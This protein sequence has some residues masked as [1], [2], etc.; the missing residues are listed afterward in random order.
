MP[1]HEELMGN[2]EDALFALLVEKCM[3]K[4]GER[5]L[6]LNEELK[7][8]SKGVVPAGAYKRGLRTIDR[9][10]RK[11]WRQTAGR[12]TGKVLSRVAIAVC[13]LMLLFMTAFAVSPTVRQQVY[14]LVMEVMD[15]STEL[16]LVGDADAASPQ[17]ALEGG[18]VSV[19]GY[20]EPVVPEGFEL[21]N[22]WESEG[23][24]LRL[25]VDQLGNDIQLDIMLAADHLS[26]S[27]DTEHADL[28][29]H[30]QINELEGLYVIKGNVVAY[31]LADTKRG[32]HISVTGTNV[33]G[34]LIRAILEQISYND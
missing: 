2:Y 22:R 1:R 4:E 7:R 9:A 28:I 12:V 21:I 13:C 16:S 23:R 32:V 27:V 25:Y 26:H 34:D 11:Q 10:F 31:Y 14:A 5:Y 24:I 30:V 15:D 33:N 29:T 3:E 8:S 20:S 19:Y 6:A 18:E 17:S